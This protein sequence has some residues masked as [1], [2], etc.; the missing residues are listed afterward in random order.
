MEFTFGPNRWLMPEEIQSGAPLRKGFALGLHIPKRHDKILDLE[1]C[2]L[3]S[4][5][6]VQVV[7]RVRRLA[8]EEGWQPYSSYSGEGYLRNLVIRTGSNTGDFMVNLVTRR[9]PPGPHEAV[10]RRT[11]A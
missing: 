11:V 3:Q 2:F 5:V 9:A 8:L 1:T 7:N 10:V 6:S 4:P